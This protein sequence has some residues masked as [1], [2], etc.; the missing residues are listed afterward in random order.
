MLR[1]ATTLKYGK[2]CCATGMDRVAL[3]QPFPLPTRARGHVWRHRPET[4]R[5]RH[6]HAE[7]ELNL[8]TAGTARFG[9]GD[10]AID[11]RAGELLWWPPGQDHVLLDA[12]AD[13]D[14]FVVGVTPE[15]SDRVL[16]V[17]GAAAHAGATRVRLPPDVLA[18]VQSLC[19]A[20]SHRLDPVAQDASAIERQVGDLWRA[21]HRARRVP[22]NRHV[23]TRRALGHLLERPDATRADIAQAIQADP[24]EVSRHF[25]RDMGLT[26]AGYRTRLRLLRFVQAV[27]GGAPGLMAA[28]LEAGF[29]S[30]AQCHR[31][32]QQTFGCPPRRFFATDLRARMAH[33]VLL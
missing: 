10:L 21:A 29:G 1:S 25:H 14:L 22:C 28:A 5:P 11:V 3:H 6:F 19:A 12:S 8:V 13:F 27:D 17:D 33:A 26:L 16:G 7:P 18:S 20:A 30:Y 2:L 15:L 9:M 4:R 23:L 31:A 32:F 24:T